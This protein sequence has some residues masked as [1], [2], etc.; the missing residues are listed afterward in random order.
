MSLSEPNSGLG[1]SRLWE[2]DPKISG[3]KEKRYFI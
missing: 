2:K 3:K 1:G